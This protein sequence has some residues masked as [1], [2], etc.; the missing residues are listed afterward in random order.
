MA[1]EFMPKVLTAN[2]L[3]LG[4]VVYFSVTGTWVRNI[5][6]AQ[7]Y[8]DEDA[9]NAALSTVSL[10]KNIIV[11]AYLFD[12]YVAEGKPI[13]THFREDFRAKGPSN[14]HHGKQEDGHV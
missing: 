10:Q 14:Y 13:P 6:D 1:R 8:H 2:D 11:G 7:I 3:L 4:D 12:V 9:A 5:V